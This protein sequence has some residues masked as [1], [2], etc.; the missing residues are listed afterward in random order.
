M[1]PDV[2]NLHRICKGRKYQLANDTIATGYRL[3]TPTRIDTGYGAYRQS[4]FLGMQM[5]RI[6]QQNAQ[7]EACR[8]IYR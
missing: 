7:P 5:P 1:A 8:K 6:A 4:V 2:S 3:A